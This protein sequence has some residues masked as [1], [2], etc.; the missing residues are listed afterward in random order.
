MWVQD[1]PSRMILLCFAVAQWALLLS[2]ITSFDNK[3]F[4]V[5]GC[6]LGFTIDL[7][8]Y[9]FYVCSGCTIPLPFFS[10]ICYAISYDLIRIDWIS[11]SYLNYNQFL[12]CLVN[13]SETLELLHMFSRGLINHYF[14]AI[15]LIFPLLLTNYTITLQISNL[16]F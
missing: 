11:I 13:I 15:L 4:Q 2:K 1:A 12:H 9:K 8:L 6:Q 16:D 14:T 3:R 7:D 5:T 10:S